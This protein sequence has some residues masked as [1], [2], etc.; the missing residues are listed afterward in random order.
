M[1][2]G[3]LNT[4]SR[5]TFRH[6][7]IIEARDINALFLQLGRK[8]LAEFG[9]IEHH[10]TDG[11]LRGLDIEA[12]SFHFLYEI[13]GVLVQAI[14]QFI[15][16][17]KDL[18]GLDTCRCDHRRNGVREEIRARTLTKEI[19][20]L[21]ASRS[22]PAN[23]AA[24][25]LTQRAG[26]DL[27]FAAEVIQF[28]HAVSGLSDHTGRVRLI[29]HNEGIV[30]LRQFVD[31]I[32]RTY[33]A[34][35]GENAVGSDDAEALCLCLFEFGL[36]VRHVAIR[37]AIA[38]RLTETHAVD[39]GSMV[40]GIRDDR[41]LF[42]QQRFEQTTVRIKTCGIK[43]S[44]FRSEEIRDDTFEFFVGVLGP[45][46]E[47]Y[48]RHSITAGVHACLG[49]LDELFVIRQTEVVVRAEVD[50]FLAAFHLNTGRLRRDNHALVLIESCILD[51]CQGLLQMFLKFL[52][53]SCLSLSTLS[54][55]HFR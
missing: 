33:I 9:I 30:F 17:G 46:D 28:G 52:I 25:S 53:H 10:R 2:S 21:F 6:N 5:L 19:D 34:V 44:I 48:G 1:R 7:R 18:E 47:T 40:E 14:L 24:E 8:H 27:H 3:Y 43:D 26:D 22:E 20:D 42:G 35:H 55:C 29:D 11:R 54:L 49:G 32:Q 4:D 41:I 45:A 38:H 31:L 12:G 37:I 13:G 50:D 36:E 16:A 23:R 15:G 39:D 51:L